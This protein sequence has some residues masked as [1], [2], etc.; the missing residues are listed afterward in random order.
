MADAAVAIDRLQALE[1]LL[2]LAAQIA[3]DDVLVFL[4]DLMMRLSCWSVS[5]LARTSGLISAC[6]STSFARAGPMP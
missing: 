5:D 3:L 2:Q 4:D 1:I 6:S